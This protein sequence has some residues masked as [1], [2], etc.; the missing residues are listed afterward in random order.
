MWIW[1]LKQKV[2]MRSTLM[3]WDADMCV[4]KQRQ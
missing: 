1:A 3:V 4:L 2:K